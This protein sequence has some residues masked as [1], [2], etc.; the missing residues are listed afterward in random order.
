MIYMHFTILFICVQKF[1]GNILLYTY[2]SLRLTKNC[3]FLLTD[4]Q[5]YDRQLIS[6]FCL[7]ISR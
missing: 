1:H 3:L 6:G 4:F 2:A 5:V 7:D